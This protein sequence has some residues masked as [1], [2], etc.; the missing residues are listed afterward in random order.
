MEAG[1]IEAVKEAEAQI[2]YDL[3]RDK[4]EL[5]IE[6]AA[7]KN[8][9]KSRT[10]DLCRCIDI[11]G[12]SSD[13]DLVKRSIYD[14]KTRTRQLESELQTSQK[15]LSRAI[16]ET[17]TLTQKVSSKDNMISEMTKGFQDMQR[18]G[19]HRETEAN[20]LRREAEHKASEL[21]RKLAEVKGENTVLQYEK[22]N[23]QEHLNESKEKLSALQ[24]ENEEFQHSNTHLQNA[25]KTDAAQLLV[26]KQLRDQERNER[27]AMSAQ[28]VAMTKEHAQVEAQLREFN[29]SK[30]KEWLQKQESMEANKK[31]KEEKLVD[32]NEVIAGLRGEINSLKQTLQDQKS[33]AQAE[34]AE[35]IS[36]LTG[37]INMLNER[38]RASEQN[39]LSTGVANAEQ[40]KR[41]EEQMDAYHVERRR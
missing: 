18:S 29:E 15:E 1:K 2:S 26:E 27:I 33:Q 30:Q 20:D 19:Q 38:I 28:M 25:M 3:E 35:K 14:L 40:V 41:L 36:S 22:A 17:E 12:S 24:S 39:A 8:E 13:I 6:L 23:L 5:Q 21:D 10:E 4:G 11:D 16:T 34:S 7:L 37:E 9:M 31:V 32:A